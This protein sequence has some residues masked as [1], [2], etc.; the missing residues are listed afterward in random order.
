MHITNKG[1]TTNRNDI[2]SCYAKVGTCTA[3]F[4]LLYFIYIF[5]ELSVRTSLITV[6]LFI[7]R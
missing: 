5:E 7:I 4:T 6:S 1:G 2:K 3:K